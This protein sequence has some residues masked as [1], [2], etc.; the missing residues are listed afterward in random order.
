MIGFAG[1]VQW[2]GSTNDAVAQSTLMSVCSAVDNAAIAN[3]V[4]LPYRFMNDANYAQD[5]LS[6]Y[7]AASKKQLNAVAKKYDPAGVFQT[8]QND[9]F[10]LSKSK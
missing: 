5:V 1:T 4:K 10:L 2:N 8:Q 6:G 9:G 7:G 3:N